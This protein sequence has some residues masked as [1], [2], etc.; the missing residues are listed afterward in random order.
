MYNFEVTP[1]QKTWEKIVAALDEPV[2][3][4]GFSSKLYNLE[5]APPLA[6]WEKIKLSLNAEQETVIPIK[7]KFSPLFRY[8]AAAILI[9]LFIFGG[10]KLLDNGSGKKEVAK[11]DKS[12]PVK[13]SLIPT[14]NESITPV[15]NST[16]QS[17]E[18][19]DDAALEASKH[20]V[21]KID[22]PSAKRLSLIKDD[23]LSTPA[24]YIDNISHPE[25]NYLGLHYSETLQPTFAH[26]ETAIKTAD[27]YITLMT[28]D[29]N[30][31]RMSK[32]WGD[33]VCCV[34]GEEQDANCKDQLQKWR[35]KIACSPLV[36]S[37][38]NFMD[39]FSLISSLQDNKD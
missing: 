38:G 5:A 25:D 24:G 7:R 11:E 17:D 21:A 37:S 22:L 8:A 28:P 35:E 27:R 19:R 3:A 33:L 15:N 4:D 32:K 6:A 34:S 36:P 9:G 23:Y 2:L 13:D 14:N 30:I 16:A 29:G 18:A 10:I 31:I 1:P 39:I 20:V 26:I 12:S